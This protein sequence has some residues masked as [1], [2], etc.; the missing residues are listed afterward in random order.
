MVEKLHTLKLGKGL[1]RKLIVQ[2]H[3]WSSNFNLSVACRQWQALDDAT[4]VSVEGD[5]VLVP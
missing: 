3:L 2:P 1:I 5:V 4:E